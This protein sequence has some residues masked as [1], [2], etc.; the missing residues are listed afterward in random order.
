MMKI[1][2]LGD[3]SGLYST[4][5]EGLRELGHTVVVA[6]NGDGWKNF[7]RDIDFNWNSKHR[8]L[9]VFTKLLMNLPKLRGFDVVQL[10]APIFIDIRAENNHRI[11]PYLKRFNHSVF[12]G[13]NGSD[14]IYHQYGMSGNFVT[15]RFNHKHL[16]DSDEYV[17]DTIKSRLLPESIRLNKY[18]ADECDGITACCTEYKLAY[19][20]L[21]SDKTTFIPLPIKINDYDF[22]NTI[23]E[24]TKKIKFFL[25]IQE[26]RKVWKGMDVI[27]EALLELQKKYPNDVDLQIARSVPFAQYQ[28]MMD[29]SHI[30]CDQLYSYGC[31]M[32]GAMAMAKGL[33]VAGGGEEE[34][35]RVFGETENKPLINLPDT[36]GEVVKVM[37]SVLE[38]RKELPELALK[39]REFALKHHDHIKVAQQYLDFWQS[40][41]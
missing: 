5:A 19:N 22:I 36:K 1:L 26:T 33:I 3:Y 25:G 4:L 21:Y 18:V 16:L 35:Y 2:L 28:T 11:F 15:S 24:D 8:T 30:L 12:L 27:Y 17:K 14:S 34:M 29:S 20:E 40:K 10:I 38:R 31:G 23:N 37:E 39:S 9:S 32:N 7:P 41:M 13:A 6:S